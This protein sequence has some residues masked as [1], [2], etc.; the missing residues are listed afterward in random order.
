MLQKVGNSK[1]TNYRIAEQRTGPLIPR[2]HAA[3]AAVKRAVSADASKMGGHHTA[4]AGTTP[5]MRVARM[6]AAANF[7]ALA[8]QT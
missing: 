2:Y 7:R 3:L 8:Q 6:Q 5:A 4:A 1:L